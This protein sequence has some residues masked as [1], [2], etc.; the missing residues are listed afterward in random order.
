MGY[1]WGG[2]IYFLHNFSIGIIYFFNGGS[3]YRY[4]L[5][6]SNKISIKNYNVKKILHFFYFEKFKKLEYKKFQKKF[7]ISKKIKRYY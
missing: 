2:A 3:N 4:R 7:K 6:L 1:S 5:L